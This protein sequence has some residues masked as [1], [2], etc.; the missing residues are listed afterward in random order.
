MGFN[1]PNAPA[2][3]DIFSPPGGPTF[4]WD[5]VTWKAQTQGVPVTVYMLDTAPTNPAPGQL[6]WQSSTG[7]MF[8]WYADPDS[9]QWIQVSGSVSARPIVLT[10]V[11]ASSTYTRP[12]GLRYLEVTCYGGGGAGGGNGAA[13][14][15]MGGHGSGGNGG[16]KA[17]SLLTAGDVGPSQVM[18]IGVGGLGSVGGTGGTG[19]STSFGTIV[20]A[21]GGTGGGPQGPSNIV[22]ASIPAPGVVSTAGQVRGWTPIGQPGLTNAGSWQVGGAGGEN[23]LGGAGPFALQ[24]TSYQGGVSATPNTGGGGG[25]CAGGP[26]HPA[27]AGGNGGSGV[28]FLKEYF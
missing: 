9:A 4:S 15:G 22:F 23:D 19:G 20:S 25:G 3:G 5:G 8:V 16:A 27:I 11:T 18:T 13:T 12:I 26:N 1:F 28:I 24:T 17:W 10:T 21:A 2:S 14:A 7:N 6:W